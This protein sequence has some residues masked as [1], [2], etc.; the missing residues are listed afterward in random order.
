MAM[1]KYSIMWCRKID[2]SSTK[3]GN[4][5][6]SSTKF[7]TQN[8]VLFVRSMFIGILLP[9]TP[10]SLILMED[11]FG[12]PTLMAL[13]V[14]FVTPQDNGFHA[15][16]VLVELLLVSSLSSS[17][18]TMVLTLHGI[19]VLEVLLANQILK[20]LLSLSSLLIL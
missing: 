10:S 8:Q 19:K 16:L 12:T 18:Y 14:F 13:V 17:F 4:S 9:Q 20:S 2:L 5:N 6:P 7:S 3:F 11:L 15:T 1:L